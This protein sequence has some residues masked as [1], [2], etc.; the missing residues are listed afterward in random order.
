MTPAR[1][2]AR[3]MEGWNRD[4]DHRKRHHRLADGRRG[5]RPAAGT[6]DS[7]PA[8]LLPRLFHAHQPTVEGR[9]GWVGG[10]LSRMDA[11]TELTGTYLQRVPPIHPRRP[12][13]ADTQKRRL[14][15]GFGFGFGFG[16]GPRPRLYRDGRAQ[17]GPSRHRPYPEQHQPHKRQKPGRSRAFAYLPAGSRRIPRQARWISAWR[18]GWRDVP[19]AGRPSYARLHGRHGS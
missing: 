17:P 11:A 8:P 4:H 14:G 3:M 1:P 6:T 13:Q 2:A 18:T 5:C 12:S 7:G 9:R 19:C 10:T 16:S 15:F